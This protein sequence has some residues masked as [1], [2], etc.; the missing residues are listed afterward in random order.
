MD[1]RLDGQGGRKRLLVRLARLALNPPRD[2]IIDD[3]GELDTDRF[4]IPSGVHDH[5]LEV[6][7]LIGCSITFPQAH[8]NHRAARFRFC[9]SVLSSL[10]L[11]CTSRAPVGAPRQRVMCKRRVLNSTK[12]V[13]RSWAPTSRA[14]GRIGKSTFIDGKASTSDALR[15]PRSEALE[16]GDPLIDPF[17]PSI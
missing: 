6:P 12:P 9:D 16:F 7:H 15:E 14:I 13:A 5:L 2:R 17:G 4:R 1:E 11:G 8:M 10:A 3:G